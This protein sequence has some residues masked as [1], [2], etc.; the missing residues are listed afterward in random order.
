MTTE[1]SE[2]RSSDL[3]RLTPNEIATRQF[4]RAADGLD[5]DE[6]RAFLR[7]VAD[8]MRALETRVTASGSGSEPSVESEADADARAEALFARLRDAKDEEPPPAPEPPPPAAPA[9]NPEPPIPPVEEA[10][11]GGDRPEPAS[12]EP[13]EAVVQAA[14]EPD[15][16]GT[17]GGGDLARAGRD[18][19]I[20]SIVPDALRSS[21]RLLQDEQNL[22]LDAARRSR[23]RIDIDRLLPEPVHHRDAWAALLGPGF[24]RAYG[25]GR[26]GTGRTRRGSTAPERVVHELTAA[27][28]APLRDRL[29]TAITAVVAEGPYESPAELH[30]AL[31]GAISARY[32]E[33]RSSELETRLVDAFAAAFAR[34][35]YDGAASG[36]RLR[37]VTD[38][39]GRCPDCDDNALET[40]VK[41]QAFPT[42]QNHPPA[43]PGCR[44]LVMPVGADGA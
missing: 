40:T 20:A 3:S 24:D 38:A 44:C 33:W 37:W 9:P 13:E 28:L 5:E 36:S 34:G 41:G 29:K 10:L 26:A 43:H 23:G 19:L 18:A 7:E 2:S 35:A 27:V 22:L 1:R 42:G 11:A 17:V 30:R 8:A 25:G 14:D 4:T 32:R 16:P 39:P 12:D 6:V 15:A 31:A 21:K